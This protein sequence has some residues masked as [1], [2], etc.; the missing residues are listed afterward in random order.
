MTREIPLS[1]GLVALVDDEDF[2]WLNQWKWNALGTGRRR[3]HFYATRSATVEGRRV[4]IYMHRA[5]LSLGPG[6]IGDHSNGN[7]LD[8]QRANLRA[9][10]KAENTRNQ[11]PQ[12]RALPKGVYAVTRGPRT[13]YGAS[14]KVDRVS[15]F[16]GH[17]ATPE[18][19]AKAYDAAARLHHREYARVNFPDEPV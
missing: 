5:I 4:L 1:R 14:I 7:T 6:E 19:A 18:D 13:L 2:D 3:A 11:A 8:N 10:S 16:L 15:K 9:C 12:S 17:W